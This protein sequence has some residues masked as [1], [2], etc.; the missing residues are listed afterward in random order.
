MELASSVGL[1]NALG[2]ETR[3]RILA[4]LSGREL[5]VAEL[6]SVLEMSQSRV[7]AHL[8]RLR[9]QGLLRDRRAGTSSFYALNENAMPDEA[10][11]LWTVL[12]TDLKDDVLGRDARRCEAMLTARGKWPDS[13]AGQMERHYSPGRTWESATHALLGLVRVGDVLDIGAGDGAI[14]SLVAPRARS[15]TLLDRSDDLLSAAKKRFD[16]LD[17]RATFVVGDMHALP[18]DDE[19]F[20]AV[21]MLH[22]LGFTDRPQEALAEAARVLRVHGQLTV[23]TLAP[24]THDDVTKGY[25][26]VNR[27]MKPE[28]LSRDLTALKLD[29]SLADITSIEKKAPRFE[30][31]TAYATKAKP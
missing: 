18:F 31:V 29:V 8:A 10:R 30:V 2:D 22:V 1:L 19:S 23:V 26:H 25:G 28:T 12:S 7:S 6:T 5:T 14:S 11:K 20:D 4:L 16:R 3:M 13:I 21:L 15:I 17:L 24:H 9:D 27:G